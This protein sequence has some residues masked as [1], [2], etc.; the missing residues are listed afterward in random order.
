MKVILL[1]DIKGSGKK[2][3]VVTVSNGYAK[4]FLFP[5]KLA[6]EAT[7]QAI[8][9]LNNLKQAEQHKIEVHMEEA[10]KIANQIN[11]K[12]LKI[13][14]NAGQ[15]GKLFGSVTPKEV[16]LEIKKCFNI[17]I[18]KR[19]IIIKDEIKT[20]GNYECEVK[21]YKGITAKMYISVSE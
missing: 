16:S 10:Q 12:T 7:P 3:D 20:F 1:N 15:N 5:K 14:M 17:D 2:G 4:N 19:K 9:E 8:N 11:E 18:D 21:L 6:Q 13:Y